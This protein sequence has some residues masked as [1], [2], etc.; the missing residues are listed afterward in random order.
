[1]TVSAISRIPDNSLTFL[2]REFYRKSNA[3]S[4]VGVIF[5]FFPLA[6]QHLSCGDD[7]AAVSFLN[8][9]GAKVAVLLP[10]ETLEN[11]TG[12]CLEQGGVLIFFEK[13]VEKC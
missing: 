4:I 13:V 10:V 9:G 3:I 5:L 2:I 1:M 11:I 12:K 7:F 8:R 6:N